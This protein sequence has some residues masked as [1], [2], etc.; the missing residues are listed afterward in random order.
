MTILEK[1]SVRKDRGALPPPSVKI[2][3]KENKSMNKKLMKKWEPILKHCADNDPYIDKS[4]V[5]KLLEN[6]AKLEKKMNDKVLF[7]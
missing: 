6:Q 4:I 1:W 3:H 2:I 5:A 7:Y